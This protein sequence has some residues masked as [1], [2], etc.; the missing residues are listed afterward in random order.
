MR[1]LYHHQAPPRLHTAAAGNDGRRG[2]RRNP[3]GGGVRL[4]SGNPEAA[5]FGLPGGY[6]RQP[7]CAR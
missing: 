6:W 3:G 4:A 5:C 2:L 7:T 1:A